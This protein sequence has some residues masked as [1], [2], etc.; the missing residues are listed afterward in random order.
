M[1]YDIMLYNIMRYSI[2]YIIL[3]KN[4]KKPCIYIYIVLSIKMKTSLFLMIVIVASIMSAQ[5]IPS[6]RLAA[7]ICPAQV[8]DGKEAH[9]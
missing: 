4:V 5:A 3:Y 7:V 6:S 8:C 9:F 2:H 1:S